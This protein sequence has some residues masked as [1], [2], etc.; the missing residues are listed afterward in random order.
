MKQEYITIHNALHDASVTSL[1]VNK[2]QLNITTGANGCRSTFYKDGDEVIKFMEQNKTKTSRFAQRARAGEKI[3]WGIR[4]GDWIL[5][6][7]DTINKFVAS[8]R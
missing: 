6:D 3:T 1:T 2:Q 7:N 5:I 4:N 8:Q